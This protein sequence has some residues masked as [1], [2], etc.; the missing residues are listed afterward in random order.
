VSAKDSRVED[1]NAKIK[2][3]DQS[4]MPIILAAIPNT[5]DRD[6][7]PDD[8]EGLLPSI[9]SDETFVLYLCCGISRDMIYWELTF[10]IRKLLLIW[11]GLTLQMFSPVISILATANIFYIIFTF[12]Y[13]MKPF[14]RQSILRVECV[15][16]GV[17]IATALGNYLMLINEDHFRLGEDAN[18]IIGIV[19]FVIHASFFAFALGALGRNLTLR[20]N[21]QRLKI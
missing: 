11:I 18:A 13:F 9:E 17:V 15:S 8:M 6:T 2:L 21:R 16:I 20:R 12:S 1:Q 5:Q 3:S 14:T 10:Y 4:D 7:D 19:L